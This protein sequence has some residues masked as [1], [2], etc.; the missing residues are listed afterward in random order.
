MFNNRE[1]KLLKYIKSKSTIESLAD[2]TLI[3]L[4]I[5]YPRF[6][7]VIG[8]SAAFLS[9]KGYTKSISLKNY[10]IEIILE[11]DTIR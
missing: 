9:I 11:R 4:I 6:S 1:H 2:W 10:W 3:S 7:S 5:S 8:H